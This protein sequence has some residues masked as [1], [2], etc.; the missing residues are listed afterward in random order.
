MIICDHPSKKQHSLYLRFWPSKSVSE[1]QK[2]EIWREDKA[3]VSQSTL[4]IWSY[5]ALS[6]R[7]HKP[8]NDHNQKCKP[9][10]FWVR[11]SH[12][13][14]M[15]IDAPLPKVTG[16]LLLR[17]V[18]EACQMFMSA[19][20]PIECHCLACTGSHLAG[21]HPWYWPWI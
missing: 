15:I 3:K 17:P 6:S 7:F 8:P 11:W 2:F 21:N 9:C 20:V 12:V 4:Q 16:V 13:V 5:C 1:T 10:W 19:R 14:S 18:S